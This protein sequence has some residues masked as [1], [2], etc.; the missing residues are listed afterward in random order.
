MPSMRS[1]WRR[2]LPTGPSRGYNRCV[3]RPMRDNSVVPEPQGQ[4][5][6]AILVAISVSIVLLSILPRL[7]GCKAGRTEL[8]DLHHY[9]LVLSCLINLITWIY[10]F[11]QEIKSVKQRAPRPLGARWLHSPFNTIAGR[12]QRYLLRPEESGQVFCGIM[13]TSHLSNQTASV[14]GPPEP[15]TRRVPSK[16]LTI[17][18]RVISGD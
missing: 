4:G 14:I 3:W 8:G 5:K 15:T 11:N 17:P 2:L 16:R 18:R 12:V 9:G 7:N 1:L 6:V 10:N 13:K